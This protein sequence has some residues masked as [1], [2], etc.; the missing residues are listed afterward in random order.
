MA[1]ITVDVQAKVV[2]Y[3][4]S[5]KALQAALAK[6]DPGSDIGKKLTAALNQAQKQVQDLGKNMF[7]KASSDTQIDAIV[8]KINR[9]GEA[10]QNV[11]SMMQNLNL[12]DLN[13]GSLNEEIAAINSQMQNLQNSV[14][15][16][17]NNGIREAV[18][19]SEQ[20]KQVFTELG[21]N[22]NAMTAESGAKALSNGLAQAQTDAEKATEAFNNAHETVAKLQ[23][24]LA[25][26][27]NAN[28]FGGDFNLTKLLGDL[29]NFVD[30][31]KVLSQQ[32]LEELRNS[33]CE[34]IASLKLDNGSAL[35]EKVTALFGEIDPK[36]SLEEF[37]QK[38]F[39]IQTELE[40]FGLKGKQITSILGTSG[41]GQ[42]LFESLVGFDESSL[43]DV[44]ERLTNALSI[45]RS[46]FTDNQW[47]KITELIDKGS[48]EKASREGA[49]VIESAY[50]T[51]AREIKAGQEKISAAQKT[52]DN[53]R[54]LMRAASGTYNKYLSAN[55]E[56]SRKI[57]TLEQQVQAQG[58]E[59]ENLRKQNYSKLQPKNKW[60]ARFRVL[61][62]VGLAFML[63]LEWQ[64][65]LFVLLFLP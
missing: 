29:G 50:N 30:P 45:F 21:V 42:K 55:E 9:A 41:N 59:I 5:I 17:F 25:N 47:N 37:K 36:T 57:L 27:K 54:E 44:K 23:D 11:S 61:S 16:T 46:L 40:Q 49:Q 22:I 13:F 15:T 33:I 51:Y 18:N 64:V 6:I 19:N 12:G 3:E 53:S 10:I 28:L 32:K 26:I 65:M 7:P 58:K 60:W 24:G 31:E 43:N 34:R 8:E 20:L 14:N 56:Y 62:N 39:M 1:N 2:G 63:P 4:A 35:Q 52:E 38:W 48:I